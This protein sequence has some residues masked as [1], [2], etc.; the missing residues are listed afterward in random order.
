MNVH[1]R[2]Y[3]SRNDVKRMADAALLW[4]RKRRYRSNAPRTRPARSPRGRQTRITAN[5]G[6]NRTIFEGLVFRYLATDRNANEKQAHG[7]DARSTLILLQE[8]QQ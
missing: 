6:N 7:T 4:N 1:R 5:H 3:K 2:H 8:Q